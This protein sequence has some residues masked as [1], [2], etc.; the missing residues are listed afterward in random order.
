MKRK[1]KRGRN[2]AAGE[3]DGGM[4]REKGEEKGRK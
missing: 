3:T 2:K 4:N 1:K